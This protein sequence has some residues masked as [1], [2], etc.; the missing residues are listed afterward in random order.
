M[1][2][3][4]TYQEGKSDRIALRTDIRIFSLNFTDFQAIFSYM[5][6]FEVNVTNKPKDFF[7][8]LHY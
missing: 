1:D 3:Q 8:F 7:T 4:I 6:N 2:Y 5:K